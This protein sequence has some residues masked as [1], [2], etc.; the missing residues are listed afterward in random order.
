MESTEMMRPFFFFDSSNKS[1]TF[2]FENRKNIRRFAV[3][4]DSVLLISIDEGEWSKDQVAVVIRN[5][6]NYTG[7]WNL[8]DVDSRAQDALFH[9]LKTGNPSN[10]DAPNGVR[11]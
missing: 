9:P 6:N 1:T 7:H 4:P 8:L 10:Q 3:S 11:I 2:P 5:F